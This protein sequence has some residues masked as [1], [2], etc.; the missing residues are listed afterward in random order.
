[1][2]TRLKAFL[3]G[4]MVSTIILLAGHHP[5][6]AAPVGEIKTAVPEFGYENPVP[7]LDGP[8][9][10][11]WMLLLYDSLIGITT[12]GNL[13]EKLGLAAKWEMSR[14]GLAWT[15]YL[16]KGVKFHDGVEL[17]AK[18]V[19]FSIEQLM[20]PDS[21]ATTAGLLRTTIKNI[22]VKDPY[23]VIIH[24]KKPSLLL[25][26]FLSA[27]EGK[28]SVVIPKDYF[29]KVGQDQFVKRPIGSGPYRWHSQMA[30]SVIK[31]EATDK[32][33]RDGVPRYK[34]MTFLNV[35]EEGSL[36]AMLRTGEAD[37]IPVSRQRVKELQ[38][39]GFKLI[40]KKGD[41]VVCFNPLM[42]WTSPAFSDIRFRKALNLAIDKEAINS[43]IFGGMVE[44]IATY[45][46]PEAATCGGDP[47]L[48][49]Y[50]SYNPK[51]AMRLLKESGLEGFEFLVPSFKRSSCPEMQDVTEAAAGYWQK[52]GLKPKIVMTE[53]S[54][55]REKWRT[56]KVDNTVFGVD[57]SVAPGCSGLLTRYVQK[58]SSKDSMTYVKIPE[59][60]QMFDKISKSLDISEVEQYMGKMYRYIYDQYL[61]V[62]I[63]EI[64]SEYM[65]SKKIPEWDMGRGRW[66]RNYNDLIKE[67]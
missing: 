21:R 12:E 66:N 4:V 36:I 60:D 26:G 63:C 30:G 53:F 7:R 19:K 37:V 58:F 31:L 56:Q 52:V 1:M 67:R 25:S 65:V 49:V 51:E 28:D 50:P 9:A 34:Y 47:K 18:D 2:K 55:F 42:Q 11:D 46:G 5:V 3:S 8:Q 35:P 45:P 48:P 59:L 23:T 32:H 44:P 38:K 14:D 22:E 17:T 13:S 33:W 43:R 41:A 29:E 54:T 39:E 15:F 16:R 62:P 6:G 40:S 10:N 27:L 61:I 24:C 64:N 20:L 57:S